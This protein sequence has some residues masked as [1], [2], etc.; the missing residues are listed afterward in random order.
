MKRQAPSPLLLM[1][2][3][4]A[5][6]AGCSLFSTR[7]P[8]PPNT[9]NTFI[10]IPATSP[11]IL[12]Q[13]LT[14]TLDL[15]DATDY[16]RVFV[17]P[18]D[19]TTSSQKTFAFHP[20]PNQN[21]QTIF[22]NWTTQSELAWVQKLSLALPP[23]SKLIVTFS[24]LLPDQSGGSNSA[25]YSTNYAISIPTSSSTSTIPSIV[26]GNLQMQLAL[27]STYLGTKEWRIVSWSDN[28]PKNGSD[29]TWTYL[30]AQLSS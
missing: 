3:L 12:I 21:S 13:N 16:I 27:V 24:N 28:L 2:A 8:E 25:T 15:L 19:S 9:A 29:T 17:S 5:I 23:K 18:T 1:L 6:L 11:D 22:A 7:T 10:W 30:K 14:G 20:A 4:F 26:Q